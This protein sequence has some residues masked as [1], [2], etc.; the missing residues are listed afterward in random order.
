LTSSDLSVSENGATALLKDVQL[1]INNGVINE[2][3]LANSAVT[4]IKIQKGDNSSVLVTNADGS[5]SWVP[6]S[7]LAIEPWNKIATGTPAKAT[8]NTDNIYQM[9]RVSIGATAIPNLGV[10]NATEPQF[11]VKGNTLV[12]GK[13]YTT[14]SVYADYVFE[15]YFTGTSLINVKYDFK[16]LAYVKEF[17][18]ENHHL[19]GV[20]SITD[21]QK[22][23][24]GYQFDVTEL[25]IQQLEKLEELYLHVIEQQ[26]DIDHKSKEI[27]LLKAKTSELE[28]R[29]L[30]LEK[31]L[32]K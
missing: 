15:K 22:T 13:M 7:N 8:L 27:E 17:I 11:Y 29:L 6:Q 26:E 9:G 28:E 5:V 23:A 10:S 31:L 20:T 2:A 21:L 1:N 14:N 30:R 25:S 3:K 32:A 12:D 16:S 19:P 18:K 24:N 4:P